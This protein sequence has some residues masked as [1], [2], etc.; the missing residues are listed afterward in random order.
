MPELLVRIEKLRRRLQDS[1]DPGK[2]LK[3]SRK[4]DRLLNHY[5]RIRLN[6]VHVL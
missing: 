1:D 2:R 4:L 3:L 6:T 5:Y